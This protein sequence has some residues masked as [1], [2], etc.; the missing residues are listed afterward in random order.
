MNKK[1]TPGRK[2]YT[3]RQSQ[4]KSNTQQNAFL[5][6][7]SIGNCTVCKISIALLIAASFI[8]VKPQP[9]I[10]YKNDIIKD[11][12]ISSKS[13]TLRIVNFLGLTPAGI[14]MNTH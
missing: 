7:N 3:K 1:S 10:K 12:L 9:Q 8:I 14:I 11:T 6:L 4:Q 5:N 13:D 2:V